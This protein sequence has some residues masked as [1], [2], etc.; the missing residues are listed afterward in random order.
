MELLGLTGAELE[1]L[2]ET[3]GEKPYRGRQLAEWIYKKGADRFEA[4]TNLPAS[5]RTKL[6]QEAA[7][8]HAEVIARRAASDGTAKF[9]LRLADYNIIECVFLPYPDR[10]T[11][12]VSTQVGCAAG[13]SFC[14]TAETGFVRNLTVGEIVD[15]VITIQKETVCR[16]TNVVF[17]GMG[18]PLLNYENV[19][20]ALHILNKE[21]GIG[22]RKMTISTVGITPRIRMLA[23]EKLQVTLA[24]SLHAPTQQLREK[25]IPYA[26]R[27][28]LKELIQVCREYSEITGRRVT[29][30][31]LLIAGINDSPKHAE[32]L[33]TLIGGTLSNVNLIP[34][35]LVEGK[36]FK[37]PD[38]RTVEAFKAVLERR[39]IEAVEREERGHSA[40]AACGQLKGSMI[41][42]R[43]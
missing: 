4:M 20:R 36:G 14:A 15:Q 11:A 33:A 34:Y 1:K 29:Y 19:L 17:M 8:T 26:K 13:C 35:N 27:Y 7:L 3:L 42:K 10:I 31:Y 22:M 37:R 41:Q 25:I 43:R 16:V 28:P 23:E 32:K 5:F 6:A 39:G 21:I 18:E 12:C 30:E 40:A 38:E 9:A 2:A 24:V